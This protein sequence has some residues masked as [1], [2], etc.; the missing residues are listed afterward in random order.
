MH[1]SNA[2][3]IRA[4]SRRVETWIEERLAARL[5]RFSIVFLRVSLGLVFLGFGVLKFFPGVS[6]AE[7][8]AERTMETLTLGFVP[9]NV[10]IVGVALVET[11]IG[12]SLT[13]GRYRR[14]GLALL[15]LAMVG[16][17]SPLVLFPDDL[18]TRPYEPTLAGQ[19]VFKDIVLLAAALVVAVSGPRGRISPGEAP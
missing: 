1:L 4:S 8:L 15:G 5:A 19:Y 3:T 16:V 2:M 13:T 12:L 10:G 18:F 17:L 11:A 14:F 9:G 7:D 6:P